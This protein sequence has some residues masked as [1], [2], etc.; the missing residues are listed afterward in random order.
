MFSVRC[1]R[2][3]TATAK[4][5]SKFDGARP[6]DGSNQVAGEAGRK[7]CVIA[8][9]V[10]LAEALHKN[11]SRHAFRRQDIFKMP[12]AQGVDTPFVNFKQTK[13]SL[14]VAISGESDELGRRF[15]RRKRIAGRKMLGRHRKSRHVS[16][17]SRSQLQGVHRV[18]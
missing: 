12:Q 3:F 6:H 1:I 5:L 15:G 16:V 13:K 9:F 7:L 17:L 10:E 18:G 8:Q 11:L 2:Q 14:L 4:S